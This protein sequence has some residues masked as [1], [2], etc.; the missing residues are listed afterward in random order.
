MKP[1]IANAVSL[2][3]IAVLGLGLGAG[4]PTW[5]ASPKPAADLSKSLTPDYPD[6]VGEYLQI[7]GFKAAG[8]PMR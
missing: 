3:A 1:N 5:A 6:V 4:A 2:A 8:T 7:P